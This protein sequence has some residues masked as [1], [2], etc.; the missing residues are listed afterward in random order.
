[1]QPFL[2]KEGNFPSLR[3]SSQKSSESEEEGK[4]SGKIFGK[5]PV[6]GKELSPFSR[7]FMV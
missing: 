7:L 2:M 6:F 4:Y 5:E 3:R 1:M